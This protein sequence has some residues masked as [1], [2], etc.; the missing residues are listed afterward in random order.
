MDMRTH[1]KDFEIYYN[2]ARE[3]HGVRFVRARVPTIESMDGSGDVVIPYVNEN[4]KIIEEPFD[5]VVLSVGLETSPEVIKLA[6]K[7]DIDLS[8]GQFCQ[9]ESF[10]PV[11]TNREGIYVCGAFQGP[12]DIPQSV[13]EA[14]SAAAEA[15]ALLSKARNTLTT[16]KEIPKEKD[17]TGEESRIGVF[18]CHCGI[19]IGGIVQVPDV[20]QYAKPSPTWSMCRRTSSPALKMPWKY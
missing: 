7:L 16:E 4:E 17:I 6:Q 14:S 9:T 1:G 18:V 3:K 12:K 2:D 11:K 8:D 20:A 15:G 5:M 10:H 19:N 13:I